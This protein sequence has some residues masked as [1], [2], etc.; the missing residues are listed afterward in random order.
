M[1]STQSR[2]DGNV[3][4]MSTRLRRV[5]S[6]VMA[7]AVAVLV[8]V[9]VSL[10]HH[11]GGSVDSGAAAQ[12]TSTGA[13]AHGPGSTV[14]EPASGDHCSMSKV[15]ACVQVGASPFVG[16]LLALVAFAV[17]LVVPRPIRRAWPSTSSFGPPTLSVAPALT[18]LCI[19][20][21]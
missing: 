20:R 1:T 12:R 21:T 11:E 16:V 19:S 18:S 17:A 9:C 3:T 4:D 13:T 6:I 5:L 8:M 15:A 10:V 7:A 14:P 2:H